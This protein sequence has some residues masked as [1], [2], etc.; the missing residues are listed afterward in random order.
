MV[1]RIAE[2]RGVGPHDAGD[3]RSPE[4][5]VI[6]AVEMRERSFEPEVD[7]Q[8][9]D[10]RVFDVARR[11]PQQALGDPIGMP[12]GEQRQKIADI[13][14]AERGQPRRPAAWLASLASG[15]DSPPSRRYALP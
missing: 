6:A 3:A 10:R 2:L 11:Q 8:G 4:R 7:I 12:V 9:G 14:G 15:R 1:V 5:R 13:A